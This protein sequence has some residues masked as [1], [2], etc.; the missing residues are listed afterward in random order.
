MRRE[1]DYFGNDQISVRDGPERQAAYRNIRDAIGRIIRPAVEVWHPIIGSG[2]AEGRI[3]QLGG[4][5]IE[6]ADALVISRIKGSIAGK[7]YVERL[8]DPVWRSQRVL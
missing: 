6:V 8:R 2:F 5:E 3:D 7:Y 4:H 1:I